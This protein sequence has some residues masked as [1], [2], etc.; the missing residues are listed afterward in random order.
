MFVTN[1]QLLLV[2]NHCVSFTQ[3]AELQPQHVEYMNKHSHSIT[4][5]KHKKELSEVLCCTF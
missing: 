2:L 4:T 1:A 3:E 5:S